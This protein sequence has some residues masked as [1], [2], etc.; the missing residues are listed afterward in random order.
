MAFGC[1]RAA[2]VEKMHTH[3]EMSRGTVLSILSL[4][5]KGSLVVPHSGPE[6]GLRL[7]TWVRFDYFWSCSLIFL[8]FPHENEITWLQR[9]VRA[10]Q[11]TTSGFATDLLDET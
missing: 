5:I 4:V 7:T 2:P 10:N 9:G 3:I 1:I 11:G 6:M 8:K